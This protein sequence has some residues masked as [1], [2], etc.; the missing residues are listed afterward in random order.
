MSARNAPETE[1]ETFERY[2][3]HYAAAVAE[4]LIADGLSVSIIGVSGP[5]T[6]LE[7]P[8]DGGPDVEV[9]EDATATLS[10]GE[11]FCQRVVPGKACELTW[12][13]T[14]GWYFGIDG[15]GVGNTEHRASMRWLGAG[16]APTPERVI[17]FVSEL[18]LDHSSAGSPERPYYRSEGQNPQ[19]VM[20]RLKSY[21]PT[22]LFGT[23]IV[24]PVSWKYHHALER[25]LIV[26][27]QVVA[28]MTDA[29]AERWVDVPMR[30][31]ELEALRRIHELLE[32]TSSPS[33]L[34][35]LTYLLGAD[36][37]AR[38]AGREK[39]DEHQRGRA[40]AI[41]LKEHWEKH[42]PR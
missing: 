19:E 30:A 37:Q 42:P 34:R 24:R 8:D 11:A 4:A 28:A 9:F 31:S 36:L 6:F 39:P 18:L 20:D 1:A 38:L 29:P 12:E 14:S 35:T 26:S 32:M 16:L 27:R 40:K 3:G 7:P 5:Q 22:T 13:A 25:D 2:A 23:P 10:L 15:P 21:V 41:R 17:R 33:A